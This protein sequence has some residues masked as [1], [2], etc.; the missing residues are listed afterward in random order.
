MLGISLAYTNRHNST[1]N[2]LFLRET[3]SMYHHILLEERLYIN[4]FT[5]Q[6]FPHLL[7][8]DLDC[9]R[10]KRPINWCNCSRLFAFFQFSSYNLPPRSRPYDERQKIYDDVNCKFNRRHYKWF[11]EVWLSRI[12]LPLFVLLLLLLLLLSWSLLQLLSLLWFFSAC[13]WQADFH[14]H[15]TSKFSLM[16]HYKDTM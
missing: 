14:C 2:Y 4:R 6:R 1:K 3:C 9:F 5:W 16:R 15:I 12:M 13:C 8:K 7:Y 10:E 11:L